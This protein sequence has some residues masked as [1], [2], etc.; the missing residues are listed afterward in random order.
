MVILSHHTV[1]DA[2]N[3]RTIYR[4]EIIP[5]FVSKFVCSISSLVRQ[6]GDVFMFSLC[7]EENKPITSFSG[8]TEK[9]K[10]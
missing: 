9:V 1:S 5:A 3:D 6:N 2:L 4:S 10:S 7:D 8:L